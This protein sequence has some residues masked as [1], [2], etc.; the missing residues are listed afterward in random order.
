MIESLITLL[1]TL[2]TLS[3]LAVIGLLAVVL[4][5]MVYKQPSKQELDT[6]RFN[7]L[8]DLPEIAETLRRIELNMSEN[9]AYLRATLD[10]RGNG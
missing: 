8:H 1:Q 9:F 7:D 5:M 2:N 3:P 4:Y 10:R 6:I